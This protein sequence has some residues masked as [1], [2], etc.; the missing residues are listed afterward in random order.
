MRSL[1]RRPR[2]HSA[3]YHIMRQRSKSLEQVIIVY[4]N[5]GGDY[6]D[7]GYNVGDDLEDRF[8]FSPR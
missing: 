7:D 3:D 8:N 4:G 5:D 2:V 6:D 1:K